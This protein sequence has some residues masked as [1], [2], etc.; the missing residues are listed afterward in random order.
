MVPVKLKLISR[1]FYNIAVQCWKFL[2]KCWKS[3]KKLRNVIK[4]V[5]GNVSSLS[6]YSP[7]S[8]F[9]STGLGDGSEGWL[10]STVM[11]NAG[12]DRDCVPSLV[13][14]SVRVT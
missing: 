6:S 3:L 4:K 14:C 1:I 5:F 7:R 9:S 2:K 11:R 13:L 8:L 12:E 10:V